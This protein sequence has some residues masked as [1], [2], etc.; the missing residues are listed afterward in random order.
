MLK[1]SII[2]ILLFL[3]ILFPL[4]SWAAFSNLVSFGDSLSDNGIGLSDTQGFTR[5]SNGMV[6]V[7]YLALNLGISHDGRAYGGALT[8]MGNIA[9][10]T[11]DQYGLLWQVGNY[12][13]A[14][15]ISSTLFTLW[16]GGNDL[17]KITDPAAA[18]A[19]IQNA[20]N[21]IGAA[22]VSLYGMGA[23]NIMI[24]N[25]PDLGITPEVNWNPTLAAMSTQASMGFNG[26]LDMMIDGLNNSLLGLS[27][28]KLDVFSY[29]NDVILPGDYFSNTTDPWLG[30][31]K[32]PSNYL[33]YDNIHPTTD[34]HW[35][36][37]E[38]A[39]S[40]ASATVPVPGAFLMLGSGLLF[41]VGIRRKA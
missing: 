20:V 4:S 29:L 30:S 2:G 21:N 27:V 13:P 31:G 22:V 37:A 3:A 26:G 7:E 28:Y 8:G 36:L 32:R 38:F 35:L 39:A 10:G 17:R 33:F 23:R 34:G 24:P 25:L 15:D 5:S 40:E 14:G 6:W 41:M 11:A 16:A 18:P 9:S 1:K 19:V 12:S